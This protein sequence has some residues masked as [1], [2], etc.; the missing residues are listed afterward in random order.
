MLERLRRASTP[1]LERPGL[2]WGRGR[3]MDIVV[4]VSDCKWC[5][6]RSDCTPLVLQE[7]FGRMRLGEA[8][9]EDPL[10]AGVCIG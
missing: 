9:F 5:E 3:S 2:G 7:T 8:V 1:S 4:R 10:A 6:A